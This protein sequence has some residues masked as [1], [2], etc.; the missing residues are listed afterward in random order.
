MSE[1]NL[2]YEIKNQLNMGVVYLHEKSNSAYFTVKAKKDILLLINIFNGHL[3][4]RK[5]QVQFE[6]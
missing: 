4:L 5:K 3:F 2:L 6:K 1:L